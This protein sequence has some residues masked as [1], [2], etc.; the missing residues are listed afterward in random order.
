MPRSG[1][2]GRTRSEQQPMDIIA[3]PNQRSLLSR[4]S[5]N[6]APS[7]SP[8]DLQTCARPNILK[9]QPYRCARE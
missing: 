2:I 4:S 6:M 3:P 1:L 7:K 8:F 9:L 5:K